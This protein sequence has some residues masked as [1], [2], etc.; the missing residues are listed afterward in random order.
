MRI[1]FTNRT[2]LILTL[3]AS[4][5]LAC[6]FLGCA[7]RGPR[8]PV[9][10]I[11]PSISLEESKVRE[12]TTF[13]RDDLADYLKR[14]E[15]DW[16]TRLS[17]LR[18]FQTRRGLRPG[19]IDFSTLAAGGDPDS[20]D[21]WDVNGLL[22]GRQTLGGRHWYLFIVGVVQRESFRPVEI[23]DLRLMAFATGGSDPLWSQGEANPQ[24]LDRYWETYRQNIPVRFPAD[25]DSY[26][27]EIDG[28]RVTVRELRSGAEWMLSLT[29]DR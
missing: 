27:V 10:A 3:L 16:P 8:S 7:S 17:R 21:S 19:R 6:L 25:D 18:D 28:D 26:R 5:L 23:R 20:A 9:T 4:T 2:G 11:S 14:T 29:G 15:E 12:L 24:S 13:W 1:R 22:L